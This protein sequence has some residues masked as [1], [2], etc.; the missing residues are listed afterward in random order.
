MPLDESIV[1]SL[2]EEIR[3]E[4]SFAEI[5][6][7]DMTSAFKQFIDTQKTL[8]RA[9]IL[10]DEKDDETKRTEKLNSVYDKLG[11]PKSHEE[12]DFKGVIEDAVDK[13]QLGKWTKTF[14]EAGLSNGQAKRLIQAFKEDMS[15]SSAT[16]EKLTA[17][18]KDGPDGWGDKFEANVAIAK[19]PLAM[20]GEAGAAMIEFLEETMAGNDPRVVKF[21]HALGS[22]MGEDRTPRTQE[23]SGPLDKTSAQAKVAEIMGNRQHP[24]FNRGMPGHAEALE[25]MK[26][27]NEVIHGVTT[28]ATIGDK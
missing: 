23:R 11:R 25:E 14:H 27:L 4:P 22:T 15:S 1:S 21:L 19:R 2:P 28:V 17:T 7:G 20:A 5:Q 16:I 6:K 24:Y 10:P 26:K 8:G 3:N 13:E 12:Y 9:V 18:L